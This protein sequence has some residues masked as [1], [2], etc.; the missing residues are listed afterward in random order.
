MT[1]T[2]WDKDN[3]DPTG[4]YMTEKYDGMRLY[5]NGSQF[6]SRQGRRVAVPSSITSKLPS[7]PLDGELW[8]RYGLYQE[9]ANLPKSSDKEKWQKATY[10]IFDSPQSPETPL[11]VPFFFMISY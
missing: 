6:Y 4:W 2:E 8:T 10:W 7:V 1:A 9:A 3:M 5:W 11:E